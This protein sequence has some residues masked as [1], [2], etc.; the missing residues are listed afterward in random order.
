MLKYASLRKQ[1][2]P[3]IELLANFFGF[4]CVPIRKI[5]CLNLKF[6]YL[7]RELNIVLPIV[8]HTNNASD[9]PVLPSASCAGITINLSSS[10]DTF[11]SSLANTILNLMKSYLNLHQFKQMNDLNVFL[12]Q[13]TFDKCASDGDYNGEI[14][15]IEKNKIFANKQEFIVTYYLI[16]AHYFLLKQNINDAVLI[17]KNKISTSTVLCGQQNASHYEAKYYLKYLLFFLSTMNCK[18]Y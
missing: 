2:Y 14:N 10:N 3:S 8:R 17:I 4:F 11:Q 18:F 16:I 15:M 1:L 12:V 7:K 13:K 6:N 5:D 9:L